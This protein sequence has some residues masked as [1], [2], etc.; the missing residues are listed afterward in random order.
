TRPR[1]RREN[2]GTS[3][4]GLPP[5]KAYHAAR[6]GRKV[7][8]CRVGEVRAADC[9]R[10]P[11]DG[12]MSPW[13]RA[14]CR[15]VGAFTPAR[16]PRPHPLPLAREPWRGGRPGLSDPVILRDPLKATLRHESVRGGRLAG[17][18]GEPFRIGSPGPADLGHG[19]MT[20]IH[21]R[22]NIYHTS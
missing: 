10:G 14:G 16:E 20:V 22:P 4:I 17:G 8:Y 3:A 18:R 19:V 7:D 9:G 21:A 2:R 6:A 15:E 12:E 11:R 5:R 13:G 1:A